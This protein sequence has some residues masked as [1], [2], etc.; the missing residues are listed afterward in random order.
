VPE[1]TSIPEG[2]ARPLLVG[3]NAAAA[4][5]P[6]FLGRRRELDR[7]HGLLDRALAGDGCLCL[8]TGEAG[9][10]KSALL[11]AF[12]FEAKARYPDLVIA[13]GDCNPQTGSE[14]PYLPF[15]EVLSDLTEEDSRQSG[16]ERVQRPTRR[17]L[18]AARKVVI[19]HGPD[20]VDIFIPGGAIIARVGAQAAKHVRQRKRVGSAA[21]EQAASTRIDQSHLFEQYTNVLCTLSARH[22][23]V[24]F[25][26]DLHWADEASVKLLFHLSRRLG[27]DPVLLVG[28]YRAGSLV[29]DGSRQPP[30]LAAQVNELKRYHGE[31]WVDL[32]EIPETEARAFIDAVVDAEPNRLDDGFRRA[33]FGKTEGHALFT[34]ELLRYLK[35]NGLLDR[36]AEGRWTVGAALS[37]EGLPARVEGVIAERASRLSGGER[38]IL[39]AAAVMGESFLAE[40]IAEA[41]NLQAREAIRSLSG[42]LTRIHGLV[43]AEGFERAG[44]QRV[45]R[46][47]FRHYLFREF[48]YTGLDE[49]ERGLLHETVAG[50]LE[51]LYQDDP[52]PYAAQLAWHF[53]LAGLPK[54]ST[55]YRLLAGHRARAEFANSEAATHYRAVLALLDGIDPAELP[56]E[57]SRERRRETCAA[58]GQVLRLLGSYDESV[59]RYRQALELTPATE[60]LARA[61]LH[62]GIA[63]AM[64]RNRRHEE[65]VDELTRAAGLLGDT[66][67]EHEP[68][69][70]AAWIANAIERVRLHYWMNAVDAMTPLLEEL[71][72][73]VERH[74]NAHLRFMF[75][76]GQV[77]R[78]YRVDRYSPSAATVE[79]VDRALAA[80][81]EAGTPLDI[82]EAQF[83]LA[84]SQALLLQAD[85]AIE[86]FDQALA[87]ARRCGDRHLQGR[88]LAYRLL[89]Y[90]VKGD[91]QAVAAGLAELLEVARELRL[92]D[93]IGLALATEAWLAWDSSDAKGALE[94]GRQALD[95]WQEH[96][97]RYPLKWTAL[98]PLLAAC[99]EVG[100][101]AGARE[102][103]VRLLEPVQAV[104]PGPLEA[105][106][107]AAAGGAD[108]PPGASW[109]RVVDLARE[110]G[111]L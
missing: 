32:G 87:A 31:V 23:L 27:P 107:E 30:P 24:L 51:D 85:A 92:H 104:L 9:A 103:A 37:W 33:L 26:D 16:P 101:E 93:Y 12:A 80:A 3:M 110:Q 77:L 111:Y 56:P 84:F 64:G 105:A 90:R 38:A 60:A 48:F 17:F 25:V 6:L 42:P 54:E 43:T 44:A 40:V 18:E 36:D 41:C 47:R 79:A 73:V 52:G 68:D 70:W 81:Q 10:G 86:T 95:Y 88:D 65:A 63:A 67:G 69:W 91:A 89:A 74:G 99:A 106:L 94:A 98:F 97:P 78:G 20:L 14:E 72:T 11:E 2:L 29:A 66:A 59:E 45:A 1:S 71:S 4:E 46:Y 19:E 35:D 39:E 62:L 108:G 55:Q 7:L 53:G 8:V 5:A 28:A 61:G 13:A 21:G 83:S 75:W 49:I 100:D 109:A 50:K 34:V 58:L 82:A 15:R 57:E 102:A 76:T 22:P 96:A